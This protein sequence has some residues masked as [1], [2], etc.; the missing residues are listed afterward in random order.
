MNPEEAVKA[1]IAVQA[2]RMLPV[3]WGTFNIAFHDWNEPIERTAKVANEQ[4]VDLIT[5]RLGE[6]VIIDEPFQSHR[7]W[8]E[9]K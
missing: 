7:W 8:D 5:P 9:V 6:V 3:S 2:G 1:H 4:D